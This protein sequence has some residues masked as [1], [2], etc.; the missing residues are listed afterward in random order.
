V[1]S[2]AG[3]RI[4][5]DLWRIDLD[6]DRDHSATLSLWEYLET[7]VLP[8][9][10]GRL[11]HIAPGMSITTSRVKRLDLEAELSSGSVDLAIEI[12][13]MTRF[14]PSNLHAAM[15]I[16]SRLKAIASK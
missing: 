10:L 11:T 3:K 6:L 15:R 5:Y 7:P 12:P 13:M 1:P 8:S 4:T 14:Q 16:C 9:L 2:A